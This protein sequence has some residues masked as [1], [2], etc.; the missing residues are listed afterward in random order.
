VIALNIDYNR[1][2]IDKDYILVD[3]SQRIMLSYPR[4]Q[5]V[6]YSLQNV[7]LPSEW[8][9]FKIKIDKV[10]AT[11]IPAWATYSLKDFNFLSLLDRTG[12]KVVVHE[13]FDDPEDRDNIK[14]KL[15][16]AAGN[17]KKLAG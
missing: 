13:V 16:V 6:G 1:H 17:Y 15:L 7:F 4:N 11:K 10:F 12:D 14:K 9:V 3:T 2:T 5:M 8:R